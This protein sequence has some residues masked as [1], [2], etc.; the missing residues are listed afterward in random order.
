[1]KTK[2]EIYD[3]LFQRVKENL[4][5]NRAMIELILMIIFLAF[6][7]PPII[8]FF[9]P[10]H[11]DFCVFMDTS[12]VLLFTFVLIFIINVQR[13]KSFTKIS[14][15]KIKKWLKREIEKEI[16]EAKE[17]NFSCEEQIK[18]LE[19]IKNEITC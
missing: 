16:I 5:A 3:D 19:E 4:K 1:M 17:S 12:F 18:K 2:E 14:D 11:D 8:R 7:A 6:F 13:T 9:Y 10:Q 15:K